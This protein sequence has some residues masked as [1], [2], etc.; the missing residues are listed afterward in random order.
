MDLLEN[1][2]KVIHRMV[3]NLLDKME[4]VVNLKSLVLTKFE[5]FPIAHESWPTLSHST[6]F[7]AGFFQYE[8]SCVSSSPID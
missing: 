4:W 5:Y 3:E 2:E 8:E 1:D 6:N 7:S